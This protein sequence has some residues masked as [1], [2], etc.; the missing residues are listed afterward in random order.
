MYRRA[1]AIA[2]SV[3][4]AMSASL[5]LPTPA[6]ANH[7]ATCSESSAINRFRWAQR[8][9]AQA[10]TGARG[11]TEAQTLDICTHA[12]DDDRANHVFVAVDDNGGHS[13]DLVQAGR[14]TCEG[15]QFACSQAQRK[16]WAWGR[17][18]SQPGCA[19]MSNVP[20]IAQDLGAWASGTD[21]FIV[22]RD[23][24]QWEVFIDGVFQASVA[25][26]SICWT[27]KRA[28]W[29]GETWDVGDAM[30][31]SAGNKFALTGAAYQTAVG[32]GWLNPA[33]TVNAACQNNPDV[34]PPY[35]CVTP[36]NNSMSIWAAH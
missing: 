6:L 18:S 33:F 21:D 28:L 5:I 13:W 12:T 10:P 26:A 22:A 2:A 17:H 11:T 23:G 32:G 1:A 14:I 29:A 8:V 7:T 15:P 35:F 19:G 30:G 25:Q 3:W 36:A 4:L 34:E 9:P 27:K 31:A 24:V 20:P 16:F